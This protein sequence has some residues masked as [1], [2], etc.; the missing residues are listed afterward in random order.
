[1]LVMRGFPVVSPAAIVFGSLNMDLVATVPRLPLPGETILGDRLLT[2]PGGKGANQ[3]VALAKLGIPTAI[4]GRV[5]A[6]GF[7]Q[8]LGEQLTAAG[9]DI[10][11]IAQDQTVASGVALIAVDAQGENQILVIPGANGQ[12]GQP[13]IDRLQPLLPHAQFLLL[14][15]EIPF[16]AVITAA[17]AANQQGVQVVLDPAPVREP[18]PLTLYPL[19]DIL[20]PNAIEASQ[21]VG[22]PVTDGNTAITAAQTLCEW[23]AKAVVVTLGSQGVAWATPTTIGQL[24]AYPVTAIDTVAAGDA[25]NGGLVTALI[26][27]LPWTEALRWGMAAGALATLK[28]GAQASLPDRA[29]LATFLATDG[30]EGTEC[31]QM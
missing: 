28:P 17:Q 19:V 4:V 27:G 16:A 18:L 15:L 8:Q 26:A 3:A 2:V 24:A 20:T 6:D 10:T 29:S 22:W 14:Q 5:G 13:E 25:F 31:V 1:M 23:G 7:G 11:G 9:V 21:L 30:S 12:V